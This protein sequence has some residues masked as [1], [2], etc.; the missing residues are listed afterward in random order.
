[1]LYTGLNDS[2]PT[3]T[4]PLTI[5]IILDKLSRGN[6]VSLSFNIRDWEITGVKLYLAYDSSIFH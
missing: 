5:V 1:M 3:L 4:F 6:T 2:F